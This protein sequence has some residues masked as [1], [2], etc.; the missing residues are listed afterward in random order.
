MGAVTK[1]IDHILVRTRWRIFQN[2]R[3][4]Q[5]AEFCSTDHGLVVA[6]SLV[7]L[8]KTRLSMMFLLNKLWEEEGAWRFATAISYRFAVLEDLMEPVALWDSFKAR[9]IRYN[10][11][12][13]WRTPEFKPEFHLPGDTG[14]RI[15]VSR[16][17]TEWQSGFARYLGVPDSDTGEKGQGTVG[18]E[19]CRTFVLPT[20][21][22]KT[23]L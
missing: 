2:C 6:I 1:E 18:Q 9:N 15:C 5:S 13:H 17:S 4:Y 20:S 12:V 16:G 8:K 7:L 14:G 21:P 19:S 10:T 22:E 3:V 23:E 11:G